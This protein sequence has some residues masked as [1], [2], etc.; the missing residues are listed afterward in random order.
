MK[1]RLPSEFFRKSLSNKNTTHGAD[2]SGTGCKDSFPTRPKI[3]PSAFRIPDMIEQDE[4]NPL[5]NERGIE[6][7]IDGSQALPVKLPKPRISALQGGLTEKEKILALSIFQAELV[8]VLRK[9]VPAVSDDFRQTRKQLE[10]IGTDARK[11]RF[12]VAA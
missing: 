8:F 2:E 7:V 5:R 4:E 3:F 1:T 9:V 11:N 6:R 12:I 10:L